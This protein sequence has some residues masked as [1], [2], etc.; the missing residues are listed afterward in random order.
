MTPV[1]HADSRA[2]ANRRGAPGLALL[3]AL[4]LLTAV[5]LTAP[6]AG[7]AAQHPTH[8]AKHARTVII[9]GMSFQPQVLVVHPGDRITW[10]NRDPFPHTVTATKG[11]F[12]SHAIA[13]DGTWTYVARKAGEYDYVCTFHVTMK[14]KLEVR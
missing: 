2:S 14:G 10:I 8:A 5:S 4:A 6:P 1:R 7:I 11:A 13:P 12:D 9:E 3:R